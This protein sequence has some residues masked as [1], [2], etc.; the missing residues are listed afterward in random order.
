MRRLQPARLLAVTVP[1][2]LLLGAYVSQYGFGLYPCEMCWWQRYA[3]FAVLVPAVLS[4]FAPA[5]WAP[6]LVRLAGVLLLVAAF[7]GL[8]HAGVEYGWWE[9]ITSCA[10]NARV[11]SG[12]ALDAIMN[13]PLTRCDIA[14]WTLFGISLAGWNFLVSAVAGVSV[15]RLGAQVD[16]RR[17]DLS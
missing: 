1:A 3:H 17:V 9:G 15:L 8:Y 7:L 12:S 10:M 11:G 4:F 2:A 13:A 14:P 6:W 16:A 5:Q